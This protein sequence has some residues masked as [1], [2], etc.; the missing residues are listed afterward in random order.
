MLSY[1][2]LVALEHSLRGRLA[3]SVYLDGEVASLATRTV[4]RRRLEHAL[5]DVRES[6]SA[7]A[8]VER[9]A[10]DR[11]AAALAEQLAP[12][13]GALGSAGWAA[14]VSAEG[15]H[16]AG[17]LS[18]PVTNTVRWGLG[19]RVVP[20]LRAVKLHRAAVVCVTD[21][22]STRL[23]RYR[24]GRIERLSS[25]KGIE[26]PE[27]SEIAGTVDQILDLASRDDW[28]VFGGS[29]A[30]AT[31]MT[32]ALPARLARRAVVMAPLP[33][34]AGEFEIGQSAERAV[35]SLRRAYEA[36]MVDAVLVRSHA[37]GCS[38]ASAERTEWALRQG[39]VD[40]LVLTR[41]FIDRQPELAEALLRAA[42]D[43]GTVVEGLWS[44]AAERLDAVGGVGALLRPGHRTPAGGVP[45]V[46]DDVASER[47][48]V[49]IP[50]PPELTR[51]GL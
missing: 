39:V 46:L 35:G 37:G 10:F 30:L 13:T 48:R 8:E 3:L 38:V 15:V 26:G 49:T 1:A 22:R 5:D 6:L 9:A 44:G 36:A 33:S 23:F 11:C 25:L 19:V 47:P 12:I 24:R 45:V 42:F 17:P 14:F 41:R 7:S 20:L 28:L 43:Q 40:E 27:E 16:F 31:A 18:V 4:W 29:P 32:A 50:A 21:A 2:E 34:L 51:P